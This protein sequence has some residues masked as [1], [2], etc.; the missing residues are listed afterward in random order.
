MKY[1]VYKT[2]NK[3]NNY[4]YIGVHKTV[5]PTQFDGYIGCGVNIYKS[6]TYEKAK[7]K[8][9]QAVKEFGCKNFH[10][11]ILSIFDSSDDAY[12]LERMLV[13]EEF[14]ARNDVYN[15]ILGGKTNIPE[16]VT[17]YMYN[18][19]GEYVETFDSYEI[20]GK[21][22]QVQASSIRRAVLYKYCIKGNYFITEK[23]P[24]I[25]IYDFNTNQKKINY[26]YLKDG[27]FDCEFE[28]Y[29][30]AARASDTSSANI[31]NA[32][33]LGYCVKGLYYFTT[34]KETTYDKAR[35]IYIKTRTVH[36]YSS[37]GKYL[38]SYETQEEAEKANPYS[39]IT[40]AIKLKSI[41]D[42]GFMWSLEKLENFNV[43]KRKRIK[44]VGMFDDMGN[45]LKTWESGR[46]CAR[47]V[48]G[49]VQ[50]VLNGKYLKHKGNIYKYL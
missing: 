35:Y 23:V 31:G 39:N 20:A 33:I 8:F 15:M 43:P 25:H 18:S 29:S 26:R 40:K 3:I 2:I 4:I 37:E 11:E 17:V 47:E 42:N 16:G 38:E 21:S 14:L 30:A 48:G 9:Q 50:N 46:A 10:R 13:N 32:V 5:D 12:D 7:T 28:S 27:S 49:A 36:K 34:V 22:L 1:I 41:D 6:D 44:K 45:L 24:K 19:K